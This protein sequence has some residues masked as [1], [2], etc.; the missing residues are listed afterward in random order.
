MGNLGYFVPHSLLKLC[1]QQQKGPV[2][3]H[4]VALEIGGQVVGVGLGQIPTGEFLLGEMAGGE[5]LSPPLV[6]R[7][8]NESIVGEPKIK[9]AQRRLING[10]AHRSS[11]QK[12]IIER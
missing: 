10:L 4:S 6:E 7:G 8:V 2:K 1:A 5:L 3:F 12:C 11:L 9:G